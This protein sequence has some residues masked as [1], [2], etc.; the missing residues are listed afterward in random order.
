MEQ[1]NQQKFF[2]S[3]IVSF[4]SGTTNAQNPEQGACHWQ[5]MCCATRVDLTHY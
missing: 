2:V 4:E 1:K 3:M 5:S